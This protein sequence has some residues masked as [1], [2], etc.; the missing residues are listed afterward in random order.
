MGR[1][2]Q[3]RA[4][5]EAAF[6]VPAK[7]EGLLTQAKLHTLEPAAPP[8]PS[9]LESPEVGQVIVEYPKLGPIAVSREGGQFLAPV[10]DTTLGRN[11]TKLAARW[12]PQIIERLVQHA[13]S[14]DYRAS[15]PACNILLERAHGK[16]RQAEPEAEQ[17]AID[18]SAMPVRD[19]IKALLEARAGGSVETTTPVLPTEPPATVP[20]A[21]PLA[22]D[23]APESDLL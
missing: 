12:T 10:A 17:Q 8:L 1:L 19:R 5:T 13:L 16:A 4:E 14:D 9:P 22:H 15:I 3:I 11:P 2:S 23:P 21:A 20:P 18:M 7:G 6:V